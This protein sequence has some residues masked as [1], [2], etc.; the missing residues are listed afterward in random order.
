MV[1][2]AT[3]LAALQDAT[4]RTA[5]AGSL[6]IATDDGRALLFASAAG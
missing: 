3:Y 6:T 5:D 4:M 2:E 1:Q